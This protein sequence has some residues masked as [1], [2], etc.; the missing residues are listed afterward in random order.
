ME[1]SS[2]PILIPPPPAQNFHA[3]SSLS[4]PMARLHLPRPAPNAFLSRRSPLCRAAL[5]HVRFS[6]PPPPPIFLLRRAE[7]LALAAPLPCFHGWP[8]SSLSRGPWLVFGARLAAPLLPLPSRASPSSARAQPEFRPSALLPAPAPAP[9][10]ALGLLLLGHLQRAPSP[11]ARTLPLCSPA[12]C[13][14]S[15]QAAPMPSSPAARLSAGQRPV[16]RLAP[17]SQASAHADSLLGLCSFLRMGHHRVL[18][19]AMKFPCAHR[20]PSLSAPSKLP[21]PCAPLFE[22]PASNSSILAIEEQSPRSASSP[23]P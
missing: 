14:F 2:S 10:T 22:P 1:I 11:C 15:S 16:L 4:S 20:A 19:R 3:A 8:P 13:A 9:W 6:P 17:S 12:T 7:L 23:C 5:L 18:H 21:G